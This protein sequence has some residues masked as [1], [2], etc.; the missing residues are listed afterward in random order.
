[1]EPFKN[2][3]FPLSSEPAKEVEGKAKTKEEERERES[4]REREY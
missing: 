1:M 4:E 2:T 3:H